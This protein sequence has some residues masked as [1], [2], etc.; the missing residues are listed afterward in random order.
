LRAFYCQF[1]WLKTA[2]F[3]WL[4]SFPSSNTI[5]FPQSLRVKEIG[6][7]AATVGVDQLLHPVPDRIKAGEEGPGGSHG[8]AAQ[9]ILGA[10]STHWFE[11]PDEAMKDSL[12]V[13]STTT[14]FPHVWTDGSESCPEATYPDFGWYIVDFDRFNVISS[15]FQKKLLQILKSKFRPNFDRY[16][17]NSGISVIPWDRFLGSKTYLNPCVEVEAEAACMGYTGRAGWKGVRGLSLRLSD[18]MWN[19]AEGRTCP[20]DGR[21]SVWAR[22][23]GMGRHAM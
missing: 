6:A 9:D 4:K 12:S 13:T 15:G 5:R 18:F 14:F 23:V 11:N 8:A 3:Y 16:F 19:A 2:Q 7:E 10:S 17:Q 21:R 22:V 20:S 1:F